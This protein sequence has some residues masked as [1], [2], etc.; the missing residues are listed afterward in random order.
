MMRKIECPHK[1]TRDLIVAT[2]DYIKNLKKCEECDQYFLVQQYE[3]PFAHKIGWPREK[4][5]FSPS[6]LLLLHTKSA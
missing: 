5:N 1:N 6:L 2:S 3:I 4:K